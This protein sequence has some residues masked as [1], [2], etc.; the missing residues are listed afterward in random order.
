[1]DVLVNRTLMTRTA[2]DR[3]RSLLFLSACRE[4]ASVWSAASPDT[5]GEFGERYGTGSGSDLADSEVDACKAPGR[6]RSRYRTNSPAVSG[7][8]ALQ[9]LR[10]LSMFFTSTGERRTMP[11]EF[12]NQIPHHVIE[13]DLRLL[14]AMDAG[15]RNCQ[16]VIHRAARNHPAAVAA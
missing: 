14:H 9:T 6:Y 7:L 5:A 12:V 1:M 10:A 8:K 15:G 11:Q 16:A 2:A 3:R 4:R 13:R